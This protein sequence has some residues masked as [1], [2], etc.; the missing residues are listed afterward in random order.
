M[1]TYEFEV[2]RV[3]P[4]SAEAIYRAWLSSDGHSNMTGAAASVDGNVGGAFDAWDGYIG[5]RT[6]ELEPNRRIVQSWRTHEFADEQDDSQIEVLLDACPDGTLVTIRHTGVPADQRG[7]EE[8]GWDQNY[9]DPM[10]EYFG[11]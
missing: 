8:G 2:S 4:A 5:G 1:A 7:Y 11:A 10:V 3:I 6:L 9:F